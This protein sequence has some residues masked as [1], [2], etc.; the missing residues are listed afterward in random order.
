MNTNNFNKKRAII[1]FIIYLFPFIIIYSPLF[2]INGRKYNFTQLFF[3]V[4][5]LYNKTDKYTFT[6]F[7]LLQI[8]FVLILLFQLICIGYLVTILLRK[9][10]YLNVAALVLALAHLFISFD[11]LG[12]IVENGGQMILSMVLLIICGL[13]FLT[14]KMMDA[15]P[16]ASAMAKERSERDKKAKKEKEQRLY[17]PGNYPRQFYQMMWKNF[18][19]DWKD[20]ALFL[21]SSAMAAMLAFAGA[22]CYQ[23]L[24]GLHRQENFLIGQGLGMILLKG[25]I[26]IAVGCCFLMVF[27]LIFYLRK[28]MAGCSIFMTLGIRR[29]TLYIILAVEILF[30]YLFSIVFG[31]ISGNILTRFLKIE[32]IRELGTETTLAPVTVRSYL[33]M[34]GVLTVLYVVSLMA[35]RDIMRE[36]NLIRAAARRIQKE[37]EPGKHVK[38]P[39][40]F[41]VFL[42]L[43][44]MIL[45]AQLT[46]HESFLLLLLC[47]AGV[48][49]MIRF[50]GTWYLRK[51]KSGNRYLAKLMRHNHLYHRS[52]TISWY[53]TVLTIL[54]TCG[55]FYFSFQI[56]SVDIAEEPESLFPYEYVCIADEEDTEFFDRLEREYE[57]ETIRFPMV[58]V[59]NA[60]RTEKPE[61]R[62]RRAQ[63]QQIGISETTYHQLKKLLD[64]EYQASDLQLDPEG[65]RIYI[66]HQQD[67]SIKA[68]PIDWLYGS[69]EPFLHIGLPCPSYIPES[70]SRAF[71]EREIAGEEIG[72]LIGC[73]RQG[74]L[75]NIVVFSDEYFEEAKDMWKYTNIYTGDFIENEEERIEGVTIRQ[76]PSQLVLICSAQKDLEK[77][78][79]EM[80]T[81]TEMH[82]Y[83]KQFDSEVSSYYS[84]ETAVTDMKTEQALTRIVNLFV[85]L[86]LLAA[87]MFL[88]YV[89]AISEMEEKK[90]RAVFLKCMGM[91][92]KE[93][94]QVLRG[95]WYL[96]FW[97]PMLI[98][99]VLNVC[100]TAATFH[101]R[102][103]SGG[104]I[105]EY[106]RNGWWTLAVWVAAQGVYI[107]ILGQWYVRKVEGKNG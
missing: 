29:K 51:E 62:Q 77:L 46:R 40:V 17:F 68:Q 94:I 84:K 101:A 91:R 13:E 107:W 2:L 7:T 18:R 73:F 67:R 6:Q 55:I 12:T 66:V 69:K 35:T 65:E 11:A 4:Y 83:E 15:W 24:A 86:V 85:F 92:R 34:A 80:Q 21:T 90:E 72:S 105:R 19:H 8:E 106:L 43:L 81:F 44:S 20:Y 74:N 10:L 45:Y 22:G 52:K 23:M 89:K 16:E 47:F 93:R 97:L 60:D 1:S 54:N 14:T 88:L 63:G 78:D 41:G 59:S 70:P 28:W 30:C 75:E 95:E 82:S 49:L 5:E 104:V 87:G 53:L 37:K 98:A 38:L 27:L 39:A 33:I 9:N 79:K 99:L 76:G 26:P 100:F 3:Y 96:L 36:F 103:Y 71:T 50:G 61:P 64:P 48:F 31:S 58:R 25:M 102:M 56:V 42:I 57:V 32:L